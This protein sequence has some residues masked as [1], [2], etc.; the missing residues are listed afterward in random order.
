MLRRHARHEASGEVVAIGP[1]LTADFDARI[2]EALAS[3]R[4]LA[5]AAAGIRSQRDYQRWSDAL[6]R[7]QTST[8]QTLEAAFATAAARDALLDVW[9]SNAPLCTTWLDWLRAESANLT[10]A[11]DFAERV[12]DAAAESSRREH[13]EA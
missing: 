12:R 6:L 13:D 9:S 2:G 5:D 8:A 4:N 1:P 11:L 10:A 3:G 7:W